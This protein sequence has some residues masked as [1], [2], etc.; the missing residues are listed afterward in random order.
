[1]AAIR[2]SIHQILQQSL[3]SKTLEQLTTEREMLDLNRPELIKCIRENIIGDYSLFPT[4]YGER[5]LVY[6]DYIA[7]GRSLKFIEDYINSV[8]LPNYAN[9]HTVTSWVGLQTT[10]FRQEARSIIKRCI[11][12]SDDDLILFTGTGTTGAVNK[13]V[14]ILKKSYW[15]TLNS[16]Y[17]QNRWGSVDCKLCGMSFSTQGKYIKHLNSQIHNNNKP[18][19]ATVSLDEPPVVFLSILEHHSNLLPW[20]EIGAEIVMIYDD[21]NGNID[22]LNLEQ[23]LQKHS[24]RKYKI[25]SFI[26]ASNVTGLISDVRA[27]TKLLKS[28]NALS[29]F[30]YATA[31]PYAE[32]DINPSPEESIDGIFF[33]GHKFLGGPGCPGVLVLKKKLVGNDIPVEAGGGTVFFVTEKS[34]TYIF[35]PEEREEGGTPDIIGSIKLGLVFQLKEAVG[36]KYIFDTEME[37]CAVITESLKKIPNLSL[38]GNMNSPRLPVF[39]FMIRCG[40][41]FMHHSFIAALLNDLFGIECRGGCACAGPYALKLLGIDSENAQKIEDTL[42]E[43]YDLFRPGFVRISIN[44]FF[45]KSTMDYIVSAIEFIAE[46]SIWFLPQ[47]RFDMEKSAFVHREFSTKEGRHN[48][49]KWLSEITYAEGK[50]AYPSYNS[51]KNTDLNQ[52]IE[53]AKKIL[54]DIKVHRYLSK[55]VSDSLLE[56]P[57]DL[58]Y[59]R[60]FVL[61]S[62]AVSFIQSRVVNFNTVVSP[63]YPVSYSDAPQISLPTI[64]PIPRPES[65]HPLFPTLPKK[66]IKK[67]LNA[68]NDFDMI[69]EGDKIIVCIS[70][71]KDSLTMLHVLRH[72]QRVSRKKFQ[73]AA[74]TVDPQTPEYNPA[75]LKEYMQHLNVPYFYESHAIVSLAAEKM[76]KKISLCA[77]C[78]RMKRGILYSCARREG[79]NVLALGQHLDDLAESFIMSIFYNGKLRTMKAHYTN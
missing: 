15:G 35:N 2:R 26:A 48:A 42:K 19:L 1:M 55:S 68:V 31:A 73:I 32:I 70:G 14:Q 23:Q 38:L 52:Y 75:S 61:P 4:A 41:R 24:H 7:S 49:R 22:L 16:Y 37:H 47:Y 78:S 30:D 57:P 25:G 29:F 20:R 6:T 33:S 76:T 43:G 8:V 56:I 10:Y 18:D 59:L 72:I 9:T 13:L 40:N 34:T 74:A 11:N 51:E 58:E 77:F 12:A 71:G 79:Y 54:E 45:E 46:N 62:E 21:P 3:S 65:K 36:E 28:Y 5:S 67:V 69:N 50:C 27:I 60:W 63:F 53:S 64:I 39:S 17:Q 66:L 44:Y